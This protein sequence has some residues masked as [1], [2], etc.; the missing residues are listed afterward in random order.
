[1]SSEKKKNEF[2][3]KDLFRRNKS[4]DTSSS[5]SSSDTS[6]SS[7]SS[8]SKDRYFTAKYKVQ[9]GGYKDNDDELSTDEDDDEIYSDKAYDEV[10]DEI[11]NMLVD[12]HIR[13]NLSMPPGSDVDESSK[14]EGEEEEEEEEEEKEIHESPTIEEIESTTDEEDQIIAEGDLESNESQQKISQEEKDFLSSFFYVPPPGIKTMKSSTKSLKSSTRSLKSSKSSLKSSNKSTPS[15]FSPLSSLMEATT[16]SPTSSE[17]ESPI[18]IKRQNWFARKKFNLRVRIQKFIIPKKLIRLE[19]ADVSSEDLC[20][21]DRSLAGYIRTGLSVCGLGIGIISKLNV[22]T[23]SLVCNYYYYYYI[24]II[25]VVIV[26]NKYIITL[27][28]QLHF[29]Y[30]DCY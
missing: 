11:L 21:T 27:Q 7:S 28:W 1:M 10:E 14:E 29:F 25:D 6:S 17:Q 12:H 16:T 24:I 3:L 22:S 2:E 15:F 19:D 26:I 30:M 4:T 23:K 8:T 9:P 18:I 20:A 5:S 13:S